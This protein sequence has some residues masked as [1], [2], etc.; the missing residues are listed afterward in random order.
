MIDLF[1]NIILPAIMMVIVPAV[2]ALITEILKNIL[3]GDHT[4]FARIKNYLRPSRASATIKVTKLYNVKRAVWVSHATS[5][6]NNNSDLIDSI[7]EF[8]TNN[9]LFSNSV[10]IVLPCTARLSSAHME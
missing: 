5:H 6:N 4:Y 10:N 2:V 1:N 9:N 8:L 3:R 7:L